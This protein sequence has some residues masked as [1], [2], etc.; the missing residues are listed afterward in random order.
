M[1]GQTIIDFLPSM[2]G[3]A[4]EYQETIEALSDLILLLSLQVYHLGNRDRGSVFGTVLFMCTGTAEP[5]KA[6]CLL[7]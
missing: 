3:G 4:S 6:K 1:A 5:I 2:I 7:V